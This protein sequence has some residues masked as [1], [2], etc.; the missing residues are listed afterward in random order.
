M[1]IR[2]AEQ[3]YGQGMMKEE[4][5]Q[6]C[7]EYPPRLR[8][9]QL[10]DIER[11][12]CHIGMVYEEGKKILDIGGGIGLFSVGCAA[13]SMETFLLDDFKDEVNKQEGDSALEP[14]RKYGVTI[15]KGDATRV[16]LPFEQEFFDVV[17]CF[18]CIEHLHRSPRRLLREVKRVLKGGGTF[19]LGAPNAVDILSRMRV[20]CGISNWSRFK[21]WYH[22]D[23]FRGHVREITCGELRRIVED[24][25]FREV[26]IFGR[27]WELRKKLPWVVSVPI[28][29]L[30]QIRPSLSSDIYVAARK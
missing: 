16:D 18:D 1:Q 4:L 22:V 15:L 13:L 23:E 28:D 17:T 6:L 19:V 27:N 9:V 24:C 29:K 20:L 26:K 25:N 30:L 21:D 5:K 10:Q 7:F 14:H 12:G 11:I 8:E 2:K 3:F